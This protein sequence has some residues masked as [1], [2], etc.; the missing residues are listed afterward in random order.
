MAGSR[1]VLTC[2]DQQLP[3]MLFIATA[4]LASQDFCC[5]SARDS[6]LTRASSLSAFGRSVCWRL[7]ELWETAVWVNV[8]Q[9]RPAASARSTRCG[10]IFICRILCA[11][12]AQL[13]ISSIS[14]SKFLTV[15]GFA[16]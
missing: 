5:F 10:V 7:V 15:D 6:E 16:L 14:L 12:T 4:D 11:S 1:R 3:Q 9:R 2:W 13:A 8:Q